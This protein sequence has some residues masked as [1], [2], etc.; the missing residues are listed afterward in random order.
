M[1]EKITQFSRGNIEFQLPE[2]IKS[3]KEINVE[4]E[5]GSSY[6]GCFTITASDHS[7]M[8]G[9]V[10]SSSRLLKIIDE[11][12]TANENI[13]RYKFRA[14]GLQ[15]NDEENGTITCVTNLG[16]IEIPFH[17]HVI[18][19]YCLTKKGEVKDLFH[20]TNLAKEDPVSALSL[21]K[22]DEFANVFLQRESN[23]RL[24]Y[25]S[26][27]KS[28]SA[29][30]AMEE[31]LIAIHKKLPVT[32]DVDKKELNFEVTKNS[33]MEKLY[34]SR[35]H[36]G[37]TEIK[38]A[39]DAP[40][41]QLDHKMLWTDNF[42]GNS[43]PLEV[44]LNPNKMREGNNFGRIILKTVHQT[45]VIPVTCKLPHKAKDIEE[46]SSHKKAYMFQLTMNYLNLRMNKLDITTFI[47]QTH[48]LLGN[49]SIIEDHIE[50]DLL[51]T[52]LY[53]ISENTEMAKEM[54]ENFKIRIEA[55]KKNAFLYCAYQYLKALFEKD[56][57]VVSTAIDTIREF[58]EKESD[59]RILW[60]LLYIDKKFDTNRLHK[61]KAI[62]AACNN[63]CKSPILYLEVCN[64][65]N[66]DPAILHELGHMER[67]VINWG[68]KEGYLNQE[69]MIQF[70]YLAAREKAYSN[71][72]YQTLVNIYRAYPLNDLLYAICALL[73]KS[74]K[75]DRRYFE[76]FSLGVDA[77][78]KLTSLHEYYM[79]TI[80]ETKEV[81]LSHPIYLYYIYN[82][83]LSDN[84]KAYLYAQII[85][86]KDNNSSIYNTYIKQMERFMYR[87]LHAR[88]INENLAIIY[89]DL[90]PPEKIDE[91]IAKDLSVLMYYHEITCLNPNMKGVCVVHKELENEIY[92]PLKDGK[93][94]V[95]IFTENA[96]IFLV[97]YND[98]RYLNTVAYDV[99]QLFD[100]NR[101][102]EVCLIYEKENP[103]LI[104]NLTEMVSNYQKSI[105]DI[106]LLY[107]LAIQIPNLQAWYYKKYLLA[108]IEHYYDHY[109]GDLLDAFLKQI[110]L[111]SLTKNE[112]I[113][114]IDYMI[115][116]DMNDKVMEA[117]NRFGSDIIPTNHM[118]KLCHKMVASTNS[119]NEVLVYLCY[120][121]FKTGRRPDEV[122]QYLI[123]Y[124]QGTSKD[125]LAIWQEA[126]VRDMDM[127]AYEERIIGQDLFTQNNEANIF[128]VFVSYYKKGKNALLIRGFLTY[129]AYQYLLK[130]LPIQEDIFD[131]MLK[132]ILKEENNF[133]TL[134][135]LKHLSTCES[136]DEEQEKF[137]E[138]QI[139]K[140]IKKNM[141][142][143]FF[144]DF[145]GKV[146]LPELIFNKY[147][148][149]YRADK[150]KKVML[151]YYVDL[152]DDTDTS[153]EYVTEPMKNV[154]EGIFVKEFMLFSHEELIYYITEDNEEE[155]KVS[156]SIEA[157]EVTFENQVADTR[158]DLINLMITS[159]DM[160]DEK[161]TLD[162]MKQYVT[163]NY[164]IDELLKPL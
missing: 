46:L 32:I 68:A 128:P 19:P 59:W 24:I 25:D 43:Y 81:T 44:V 104:L 56:K 35:D 150:H 138:F 49:M 119:K 73:I 144:K 105:Q 60:F 51:R 70:A 161:T 11:Q 145:K 109:D 159:F 103:L 55:N 121:V 3:E 67:Q 15:I 88:Q 137:V 38:I 27:M 7:Q 95:P 41:I 9:L 122:L 107:K 101:Y 110:N 133:L 50:Y 148:V 64:L 99:K 164:L 98:N 125:M 22:S 75:T 111:K 118:I 129:Y 86:N 31:F 20:F 12:F 97:D 155:E 91:T 52:H 113:D 26:L 58:Y 76:W 10:Y 8:K 93:T 17:F 1:K 152:H 40:F 78:L 132:E 124:Y 149:M 163:Q 85:K 29:S 102:A 140:F 66:E 90:I 120:E 48:E 126:Y 134:A 74:E 142:L 69:V 123:T 87:Q 21:F 100:Y 162:T 143:P 34:I 158:F 13:I 30:Q 63:G 89:N 23:Y 4:V 151:H 39:T 106:L 131:I 33:F 156:D 57:Q 47:E 36:W 136:L 5:Q 79:Y 16:E 53:I 117:I 84:R 112:R 72:I 114:I 146:L 135:V 157:A 61:Y 92:H 45:I 139:N 54:L 141:V 80:D 42:A 77:Q 71:V 116:R 2:V 65:Y 18:P 130:D 96:Q 108:L 94:V 127:V 153:K 14:G 160:Q 82:S 6:Y 147:Y 115:I 83:N 28:T 154:F 37:Y 62:K